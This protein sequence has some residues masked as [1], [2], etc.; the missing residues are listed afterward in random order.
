MSL[1]II[2]LISLGLYGLLALTHAWSLPFS[3][4]EA[5]YALYGS[6]L[7]WSYF[8][9]P[10]MVGWLQSIALIFSS[11]E[12]SLRVIPIILSGLSLLFYFI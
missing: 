12:F 8:D 4:D 2:T 3:A 7:D 5:H 9:H 11:S 6:F 1:R 10:P